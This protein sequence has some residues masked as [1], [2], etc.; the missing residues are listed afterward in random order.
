[1]TDHTLAGPG[2]VRRR[3][4]PR[5]RGGPPCA[6]GELSVKFQARDLR[7]HLD[8][9]VPQP[10]LWAFLQSDKREVKR[11]STRKKSGLY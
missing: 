6:G 10:C 7:A 8:P 1:M 9:R 4:N 2:V 11:K 5:P 3:L